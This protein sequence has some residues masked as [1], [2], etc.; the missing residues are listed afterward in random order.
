M[1]IGNSAG[2]RRNTGVILMNK[3]M[4]LYAVSLI[5]FVFVAL[6]M[7]AMAE[8]Y[9]MDNQTLMTNM[10]YDG[11]IHN[12]TESCMSGCDNTT[13]TCIPSQPE[14]NTIIFVVIVVIIIGAIFLIRWS[15]R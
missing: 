7:P 10:T 12:V 9:C 15:K 6:P 1:T 3:K 13:Y 11:V 14:Q 2:K 4:I 5:F 8:S